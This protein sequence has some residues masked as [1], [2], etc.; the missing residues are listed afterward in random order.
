MTAEGGSPL[1]A[2]RAAGI[3][4]HVSSLPGPF[5]IGDL[6]PS[7]TRFLDWARAAGQSLWQILPLGPTGAGDSPYGGASAFAGNPS[8]VSPEL[9]VEEGWVSAAEVDAARMPPTGAGAAPTGWKDR[10]LRRAFERFRSAAPA[11]L[12]SEFEAFR[13]ATE[14]AYWLADW[15]LYSALKVRAGGS[16]WISWEPRLASRDPEALA[17]ARRELADEIAFAELSQFLFFRQWSRVRREAASRGIRIVGD[18]PIYVS[19]DSA[20][21]WAHRDLFALGAD[22][23]PERVAGVP[24]DY[25][26]KTGQ[27]WGYPVYQWDVIARDG[28]TWW[29]ERLRAN[30]NR[31]DAVR[32][33]HFRGFA[34]F[35]EV[36]AGEPT[37]LNGRWTQGP[38][39]ALFD[40]ARRVLG[41]LP[42]IAEDLGLIT[43]DVTRLLDE[44]GFSGMKV[45][46]FAFSED[47]SP[48][49]P[50]HHPVNAVVY[51]GTHDNDTTS[52][53]ASALT[54]AE[55][56][57]LRLYAGAAGVEGG[58][59]DAVSAVDALIRTAYASVARWAIVPMQDVLGLGTMARMNT[60]G[61]GPGNWTW[62]ASDEEFSDSDA[63]RLRRL[64]EVTGRAAKHPAAVPAPPAARESA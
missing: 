17:E 54:D 18:L 42:V 9:L 44:T 46:Q 52:G 37:A 58:A 61:M 5:P 6:G 57:R 39:R 20:D 26:A 1:P 28:W 59:V 41:P 64:A 43:P 31:T 16:A 63:G 62:R 49:L 7:A 13:A 3:L 27:L 35:W 19:H 25:F 12:R 34:S 56:E 24:P 15:S 55:R 21:V 14:S 10:I 4:L 45:L 53:W 48:H 38:G 11:A 29:I 33:D 23:R 32:I 2:G 47:D 8:F 36:P 60:P 40:A 50:H 51:T 30:L 22:G